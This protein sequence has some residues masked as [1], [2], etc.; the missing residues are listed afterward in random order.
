MGHRVEL[1]TLSIV[2]L[3][4]AG[5]CE[6]TLEPDVSTTLT[7]SSIL[8]N[9]HEPRLVSPKDGRVFTTT[10][11]ILLR[12]GWVS[13]A[14]RYYAEVATDTSF[15]R[16]V[17]SSI[18]DTTFVRTPSLEG[19]RFYWRVKAHNDRMESPWSEFRT[20]YIRYE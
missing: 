6:R 14:K 11:Q 16:V 2:I 13:S 4:F 5:G 7:D 1:F 10:T 9:L 8:Q 20:F 18:T 3:L 19:I 12:W 17:F 15:S